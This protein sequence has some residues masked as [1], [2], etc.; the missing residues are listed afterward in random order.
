MNFYLKKNK[1]VVFSQLNFSQKNLKQLFSYKIIIK[2]I[3]I[4]PVCF[5]LIQKGEKCQK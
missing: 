2:N 3:Q 1:F 5:V 4:H